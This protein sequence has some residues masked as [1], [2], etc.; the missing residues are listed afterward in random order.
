MNKTYTLNDPPIFLEWGRG[1]RGI[2]CQGCA[3]CIHKD[4]FRR[5]EEAYGGL[6]LCPRLKKL[7]PG[8]AA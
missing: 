6:G 7:D 2:D 5:H 4:N 3:G 8:P 1:E